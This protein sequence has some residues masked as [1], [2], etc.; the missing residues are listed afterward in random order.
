MGFAEVENRFVLNAL[1][2]KTPLSMADYRIIH[3]DSPDVRG[4]D[5]ALLYRKNIFKPIEI[6]FIEVILDDSVKTRDILHVKG[7]LDIVDTLHIIVN[8][9]PSKIS[10]NASS[11]RRRRAVSAKV[12]MMLDS[13][14]IDQ[15]SKEIYRY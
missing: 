5:V 11:E 3:K 4:I 1:L 9:W 8:H 6:N 13:I 15:N 10:G 12:Q 14:N 2:S 7:D